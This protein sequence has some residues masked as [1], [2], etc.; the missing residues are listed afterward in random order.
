MR[1]AGLGYCPGSSLLLPGPGDQD[2]GQQ[3]GG[4]PGRERAAPGRWH[5]LSALRARGRYSAT[6]RGCSLPNPT[7]GDRNHLKAC[8]P[9]GLLVFAVPPALSPKAS[10]ILLPRPA[11]GACPLR[12]QPV[13]LETPHARSESWFGNVPAVSAPVGA[14]P[15]R[16]YH[17]PAPIPLVTKTCVLSLPG[18]GR[19]R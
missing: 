10:P 13:T 7:R 2:Q 1:R 6:F 14:W 4:A 12:S 19:T 8:S 17:L 9:E 11:S 15:P 16:S 3:P 18:V 5:N